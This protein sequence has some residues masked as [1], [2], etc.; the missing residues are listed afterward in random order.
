MDKNTFMLLD[1]TTCMNKQEPSD[2]CPI[3]QKKIIDHSDEEA[4]RC[5]RE[6]LILIKSEHREFEQKYKK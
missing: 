2:I 6:F 3:C 1:K 5:M 4:S